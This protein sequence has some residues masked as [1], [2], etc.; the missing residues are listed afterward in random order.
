V[1]LALSGKLDIAVQA[2]TATGWPH[3]APRPGHAW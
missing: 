3:V 2:S 1:R